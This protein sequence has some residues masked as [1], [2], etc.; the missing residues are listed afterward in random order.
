VNYAVKTEILIHRVY[1]G[2]VVAGWIEFDQMALWRQLGVIESKG[3]GEQWKRG[4]PRLSLF[5][6]NNTENF[7]G[8]SGQ[9]DLQQTSKARRLKSLFSQYIRLFSRRKNRYRP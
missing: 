9:L 7:F 3:E 1:A 6:D 8:H 4:S 2:K 5:L